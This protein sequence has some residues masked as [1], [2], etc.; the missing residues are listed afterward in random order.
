LLRVC[1]GEIPSEIQVVYD[2]LK[3]SA[4]P[5][6]IDSIAPTKISAC[7]KISIDLYLGFLRVCNVCDS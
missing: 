3:D 2:V 6:A 4:A 5:W 7:Q 1:I